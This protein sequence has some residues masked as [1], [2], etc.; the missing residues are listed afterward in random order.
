M[1]WIVIF[2]GLAVAG[3]VAL[4]VY[5]VQLRHRFGDVRHEVSVVGDRVGQVTTLLERLELPPGRRD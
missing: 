5:A 2:A 1:I 3:L 4:T